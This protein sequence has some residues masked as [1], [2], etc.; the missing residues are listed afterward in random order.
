MLHLPK[1]GL[2]RPATGHRKLGWAGII[3]RYPNGFSVIG[4][5]S[6][7]PRS[8]VSGDRGSRECPGWGQAI[9]SLAAPVRSPTQRG[10]LIQNN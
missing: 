9:G 8:A 10:I 3:Y 4:L 6:Q 7:W 2:R 5:V 1:R